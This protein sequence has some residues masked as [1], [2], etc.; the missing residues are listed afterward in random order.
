[1]TPPNG[2][3]AFQMLI[4]LL[5]LACMF[6]FF[7]KYPGRVQHIMLYFFFGVFWLGIFLFACVF[8]TL[9]WRKYAP[10]SFRKSGITI[11]DKSSQE[12]VGHEGVGSSLRIKETP[13]AISVAWSSRDYVFILFTTFIFGP[14]M[15]AGIATHYGQATQKTPTLFVVI[16]IVICGISAATFFSTLYKLAWHYPKLIIKTNRIEF[17][18]GRHLVKTFWGHDIER[19]SLEEHAYVYEGRTGGDMQTHLNYILTVHM[20]DDTTERL[21]ISDKHMQMQDLKHSIETKMRLA[22]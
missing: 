12:L 20:K 1:M 15:I 21:C 19:L 17:W 18:C 11:S 6:V 13:G 2:K 9:A 22:T 8:G 7:F 16:M 5:I 3:N 10:D 4:S 14:V